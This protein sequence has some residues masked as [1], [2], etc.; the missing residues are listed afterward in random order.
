MASQLL[1]Y[2]TNAAYPIDHLM[3]GKMVVVV[4]KNRFVL[5][6]YQEEMQIYEAHA[7]PATGSNARDEIIRILRPFG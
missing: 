6:K 2:R 4:C 7:S 5:A 3:C 1:A